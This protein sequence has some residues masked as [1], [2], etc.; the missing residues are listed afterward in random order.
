MTWKY[1][2]MLLWGALHVVQAH[3]FDSEFVQYIPGEINVI[4]S[5]PHGSRS[6]PTSWPSRRAG[7]SNTNGYDCFYSSTSSCVP[8]PNS[9]SYGYFTD[10]FT[11]DIGI[12][13]A[14]VVKQRLGKQPHVLI[15]K[16]ARKKL[17]VNRPIFN[18]YN[19]K[20]DEGA[21]GFAPAQAVYDKYHGRLA[22]IKSQMMGRGILL[23]I[24]GQAH[25]QNST[26]LGYLFR[27]DQIEDL[28]NGV[29]NLET[30]R[31]RCGLLSLLDETNASV[32]DMLLGPNSLGKYLEDQGFKALPGPSTL[33]MSAATLS[34]LNYFNGGHTV[35]E[36]GSRYSN[37]KQMDAVQAE[38]PGEI[39]W[40]S[41]L[42]PTYAQALGNAFSDF[43]LHFYPNILV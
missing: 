40:S 5:I 9:C 20:Y 14:N 12:E 39:R 18:S 2:L 41:S 29:D 19:G 27:L 33:Q 42:R 15:L 34:G 30:Q 31:R 22:Q 6:S 28:I 38:I 35:K 1:H 32:W 43:V 4:V 7:C 21:Q 24:H 16:V 11:E 3:E 26:E 25:K 10:A 17:D 13:V 36:H 23:D 8:D 37:G